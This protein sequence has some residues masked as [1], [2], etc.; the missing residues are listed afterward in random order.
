MAAAVMPQRELNIR[1]AKPRNYISLVVFTY[2]SEALRF[3]RSL[4][5]PPAGTSLSLSLSLSIYIYIFFFLYR[6]VDDIT[7]MCMRERSGFLEN[8]K[9]H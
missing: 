4:P 8:Y 7:S 1:F 2:I 9:L 5:T 6:N 3:P